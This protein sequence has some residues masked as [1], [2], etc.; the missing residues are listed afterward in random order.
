MSISYESI[1]ARMESDFEERAG[2]K[3]DHASDIGIRMKV[4]AAQIFS[5]CARCDWLLKQAFPQTATGSYLDMHAMT[6]GLSR[7][8]ATK[9]EGAL[10]F[11]RDTGLWYDVHIPAGTV[12]AAPGRQELRFVTT[13][14]ARL[15]AG[16]LS[17]T[18]PAQAEQGG[19]TYN[20]AAG[21]VSAMITPPQGI[22]YV[23]NP[24]AFT[25]GGAAEEDEALRARLLQDYRLPS[26]GMNAAAYRE[27]AFQ[28][29]GIASVAV[30]PRARGN[31]TV[32]VVVATRAGAPE[33]ELIARMNTQ[34]RAQREIGVDL[35]VRAARVSVLNLELRLAVDGQTD[36][37]A[38]AEQARAALEGYCL[39]RQIGQPLYLAALGHALY[40]VPGIVNY[41]FVSPG[42][43]V[44]VDEDVWL[45]AGSIT[46]HRL[47]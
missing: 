35:L 38:A 28:Y 32:D 27:A 26:N 14:A 1:L 18:V 42:A 11:S 15:P 33:P 34:M 31:G 16:D 22:A 7:Q 37:D 30:L 17:V 12:C 13:K 2:I 10:T 21:T 20:A 41:Q 8:G 47:A 4:L 39:Q 6:R 29:P 40:R 9:A 46:L 36:F 24:T 19:G 45:Q 44:A 43:D 25:G 23:T 5:L 3:P